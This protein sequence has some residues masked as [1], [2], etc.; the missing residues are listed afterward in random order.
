MRGYADEK[1]HIYSL[2]VVLGEFIARIRGDFSDLMKASLKQL[3][4]QMTLEDWKTRPSAGQV[5]IILT[6][7][8]NKEA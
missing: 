8:K 6:K 1:S 4:D 2:G 3:N 5:V 7:L